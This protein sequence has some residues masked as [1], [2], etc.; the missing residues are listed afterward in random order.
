MA[1]PHMPGKLIYEIDDA[2]TKVID[3]FNSAS[4]SELANP[5]SLTASFGNTPLFQIDDSRHIAIVHLPHRMGTLEYTSRFIVFDNDLHAV[6]VSSEFRFDDVCAVEMAM[7]IFQQNDRPSML[8]VT[9]C[10]NDTFQYVYLVDKCRLLD[11]IF[12]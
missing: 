4:T 6:K 5:S 1:V 8:G 9:V 12:S 11:F 10:E 3:I 7:S 2:S